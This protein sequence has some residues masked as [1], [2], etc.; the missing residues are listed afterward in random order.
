[1]ANAWSTAWDYVEEALE[2]LE[3]K[4]R[5]DSHI[6]AERRRVAEQPDGKFDEKAYMEFHQLSEKHNKLQA[7]RFPQNLP[8]DEHCRLLELRVLFSGPIAGSAHLGWRR[9]SIAQ[10]HAMIY[11]SPNYQKRHYQ[12][13]WEHRSD[14]FDLERWMD[15]NCEELGINAGIADRNNERP[16]KRAK[17]GKK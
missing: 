8:F 2:L 16:M 12:C 4:E 6:L 5:L 3:D 15:I 14:G 13:D 11:G 7:R 1:V 9:P 10:W 17:K